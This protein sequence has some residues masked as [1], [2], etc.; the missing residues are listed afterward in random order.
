MKKEQTASGNTSRGPFAKVTQISGERQ[1]KEGEA[2]GI[3]RW[4]IEDC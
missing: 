2:D 3:K 4:E 1:G